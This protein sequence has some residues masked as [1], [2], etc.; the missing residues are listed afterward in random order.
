MT[1]HCEECFLTEPLSPPVNS[2]TALLV[3]SGFP[4]I[5]GISLLTGPPIYSMT[6]P[7]IS[8]PT[9]AASIPITPFLPLG[10]VCAA[11]EADVVVDAEDVVDIRAE[12]ADAADV[13]DVVDTMGEEVDAAD[14][15]EAST[16][17]AAVTT[18]SSI[19]WGATAFA[20]AEADLY[21]ARVFGPEALD[22]M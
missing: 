8:T 22:R 19:F 16:A 2:S 4:F 9:I 11:D 20:L 10:P 15:E 5:K 13:E 17:L 21:A 3:T 6:S 14:V 7:N 1:L 12:E 18:P